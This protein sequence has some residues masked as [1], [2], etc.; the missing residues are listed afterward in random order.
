MTQAKAGVTGVD[1]S[2]PEAATFGRDNF[3]DREGQHSGSDNFSDRLGP[4]HSGAGLGQEEGGGEEGADRRALL[5]PGT[6][7]S[8]NPFL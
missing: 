8:R 1:Q 7:V 6:G 2:P 3:S 5:L 4:S